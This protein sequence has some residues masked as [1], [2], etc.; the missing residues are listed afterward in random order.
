M[1]RP[2]ASEERTTGSV[3]LVPV[4]ASVFLTDMAAIIQIFA[5]DRDLAE[6]GAD[7]LTLGLVGGGMAAAFA[8]SSVVFGVL[9]DR[10]SAAGPWQSLG[11]SR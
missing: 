5:V 3:S 7:L 4:Y 9:S 11:L 2:V 6:R 10:T 1:T 8:V